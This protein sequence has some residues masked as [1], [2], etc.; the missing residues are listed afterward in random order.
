MFSGRRSARSEAGAAGVVPASGATGDGWIVSAMRKNPTSNFRQF[1]RFASANLGGKLDTI[2]QDFS[3][4]LSRS[5]GFYRGVRSLCWLLRRHLRIIRCRLLQSASLQ[6]RLDVG[7][8][9]NKIF[10]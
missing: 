4:K 9:P 8:A 7:I 6:Q 5:S 3:T 10:E 1:F 2:I